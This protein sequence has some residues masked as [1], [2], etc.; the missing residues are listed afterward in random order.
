[1]KKDQTKAFE[2]W[3]NDELVRWAPV[4][5]LELYKFSV[6]RDDKGSYMAIT[7]TYPYLHAA[8]KYNS[9][10]LT[11]FTTGKIQ[12]KTRAVLHELCHMLTDPLYVKGIERHTGP[13]EIKDE[14]EKLTDTIAA[15]VERLAP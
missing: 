10:A 13:Q 14:R 8:V 5:G 15:I 12:A 11:D 7:C 6:E 3:V 1:M 4:L 9:E 2:K